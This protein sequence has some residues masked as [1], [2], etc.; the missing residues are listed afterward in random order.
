MYSMTVS[1]LKLGVKRRE[2]NKKVLKDA[3][4]LET[5]LSQQVWCGDRRI[6]KKVTQ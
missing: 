1:E 3:H 6:Y 4:L 5:V 2:Y